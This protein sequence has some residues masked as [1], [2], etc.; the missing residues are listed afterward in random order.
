MFVRLSSTW[1]SHCRV[2]VL[3]PGNCF[4]MNYNITYKG[5]L[6]ERFGMRMHQLVFF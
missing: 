6:S 2:G 4:Y 5:F 3:G 1:R